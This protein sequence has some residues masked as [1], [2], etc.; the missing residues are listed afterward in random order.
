MSDSL[1]VFAGALKAAAKPQ[2]KNPGNAGGGSSAPQPP[3]QEQPRNGGN[4]GGNNK[5]KFFNN[6]NRGNF[7]RGGN[8][9]RQNASPIRR[10]EERRVGKECLRLCRSRWSPYH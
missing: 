9:A 7:G 6:K 4:G 10:S 8:G 5:K 3:Q 1:D 2:N